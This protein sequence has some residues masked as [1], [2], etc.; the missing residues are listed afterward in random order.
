[1]RTVHAI[2]CCLI[3]FLLSVHVR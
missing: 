3:M 1:M 2:V